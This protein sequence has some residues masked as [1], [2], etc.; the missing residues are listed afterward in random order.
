MNK[1]DYQLCQGLT[2]HGRLCGRKQKFFI[3]EHDGIPR[4][5]RC[6]YYCT[7]HCNSWIKGILSDT[8]SVSIPTLNIQKKDRF[9][10]R[11]YIHLKL[12]RFKVKIGDTISE[13]LSTLDQVC[14][15]MK[16]LPTNEIIPVQITLLY[17]IPNE[18]L[19]II[20][21]NYKEME[22]K[23]GKFI[24]SDTIIRIKGSFYLQYIKTINV[25]KI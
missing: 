22:T 6:Q 19:K 18:Y 12:S 24:L 3:S 23:S 14:N 5:V 11:D 7:Q 13:N 20:P 21:N 15:I 10:V 16:F 25:R 2:N 9:Y 17:N 1:S 4:Y 8:S